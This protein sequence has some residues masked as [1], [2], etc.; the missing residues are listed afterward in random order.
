M[1]QP[2]AVLYPAKAAAMCT[3]CHD[4]A[5][6]SPPSRLY[7]KMRGVSIH[8]TGLLDWT[9]WTGPTGLDY[10]TDLFATKNHFMPCN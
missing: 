3:A 4:Y 8:W 6:P 5:R 9:Y 10:W 7:L 2:E 1:V